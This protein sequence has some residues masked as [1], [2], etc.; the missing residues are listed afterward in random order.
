MSS[1]GDVLCG[2]HKHVDNLL[3]HIVNESVKNIKQP[4]LKE[5]S[6]ATS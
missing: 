2:E 5:N 3:E 6:V 1:N 4:V